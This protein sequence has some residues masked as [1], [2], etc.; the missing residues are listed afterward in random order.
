MVIARLRIF[1]HFQ[2]LIYTLYV[3]IRKNVRDTRRTTIKIKLSGWN[4]SSFRFRFF[5]R[6]HRD[7]NLP[8]INLCSCTKLLER[9]EPVYFGIQL[10]LQPRLISSIFW[11]PFYFHTLYLYNSLYVQ[12]A[13]VYHNFSVTSA[14][15]NWYAVH[16]VSVSRA[17]YNNFTTKPGLNREKSRGNG[18][19]NEVASLRSR[20]AEDTRTEIELPCQGTACWEISISCS[21]LFLAPWLSTIVNYRERPVWGTF[22]FDIISY[23]ASKWDKWNYRG[24]LTAVWSALA[25]SRPNAGSTFARTRSDPTRECDSREIKM[26]A[27]P[28]PS[29][30]PYPG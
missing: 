25:L 21:D 8:T 23:F 10:I 1:M 17:S 26:F 5:T 3:V 29:P 18:V 13:D 6:P 27:L 19:T 24:H 11:V 20:A 12:L 7:M 14:A 22:Y 16:E 9:S 15:A 30:P 4:E 2:N 28:Y